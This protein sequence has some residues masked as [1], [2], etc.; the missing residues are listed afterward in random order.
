M[1]SEKASIA[2]LRISDYL[3]VLASSA[4]TPGGGAVAALSL[5]QAAGLLAMVCQISNKSDESKFAHIQTRANELMDDAV[6]SAD[7]DALAF[8]GL[9]KA[10]KMAK[11][12]P[13]ELEA[14][15]MEV[16]RASTKAADIPL[17]VMAAARELLRAATAVR[18]QVS[19]HLISDLGV[20]ASLAQAATTASRLTVLVNLKS[21]RN[22]AVAKELRAQCESYA[23]EN[24]S[25]AAELL[26]EV[27]K[28]LE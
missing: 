23:K 26:K 8:G 3:T 18:P 5:A 11:T 19:Q 2:S 4:P 16:E 15:K 14:R 7:A 12:C 9:M 20:V 28:A 10:F 13:A 17:Q 27:E 24:D 1:A 25:L 6:A 22:A 21:I